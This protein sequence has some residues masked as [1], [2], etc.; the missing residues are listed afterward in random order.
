MG[1]RKGTSTTSGVPPSQHRWAGIARVVGSRRWR[2]GTVAVGATGSSPRGRLGE[3]GWC[4]EAGD[5]DAGGVGGAAGSGS[6]RLLGWRWRVRGIALLTSDDA[7]S[8]VLIDATK[9]APPRC[10]KGESTVPAE[11][12]RRAVAVPGRVVLVEISASGRRFGVQGCG[13]GLLRLYFR[14]RRAAR[15][16]ARRAMALSAQELPA[17]AVARMG[18]P[19]HLGMSTPRPAISPPCGRDPRAQ[20]IAATASSRVAIRPEEQR[21]QHTHRRY[22][23]QLAYL[24]GYVFH[25]CSAS[26]EI[27]VA[28]E[29]PE[30]LAAQALL[31]GSSLVRLPARRSG[32]GEW[33]CAA[34]G[35]AFLAAAR[36]ITHVVRDRER[37]SSLRC[38]ALGTHLVSTWR[39]DRSQGCLVGRRRR[40]LQVLLPSAAPPRA[41]VV[42]HLPWSGSRRRGRGLAPAMTPPSR[43]ARPAPTWWAAVA[44]R[45]SPA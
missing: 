10:G 6:M 14:N 4:G 26:L 12:L 3:D 8:V 15:L 1:V 16:A 45:T 2:S 11:R 24:A 5:G 17:A 19:S 33:R 32:G 25:G 35:R 39:R 22:Q 36:L 23:A 28:L 37:C 9:R 13:V 44:L 30:H 7:S 27:R 41:A 20:A 42:A 21:L 43:R 18:G 34:A 40:P 31:P 29:D 38:R